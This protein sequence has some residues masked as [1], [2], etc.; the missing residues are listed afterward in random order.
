MLLSKR[1]L[2]NHRGYK[3]T[4]Q[5]QRIIDI[6]KSEK[7]HLSAIDIHAV[8]RQKHHPVSM[9]TVYRT[10]A[11][12]IKSGLVKKINIADKPSV[13]EFDGN[14]R[15]NQEHG[16]FV[17]QRCGQVVDIRPAALSMLKEIDQELLDQFRLD[18]LDHQVTFFGLCPNCK[19]K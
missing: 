12:L 15:K 14:S 18:I 8:L 17:C 7:G 6:L 4:T 11:I 16:H 2:F 5:R 3:W 19:Q 10:L 1:Q 9:A 13:F